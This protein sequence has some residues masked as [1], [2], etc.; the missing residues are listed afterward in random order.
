MTQSFASCSHC[1]YFLKFTSIERE[2]MAPRLRSCGFKGNYIGGCTYRNGGFA[3]AGERHSFLVRRYL[4]KPVI[5]CGYYESGF[6]VE[7]TGTTCPKCL[8]GLIVI[9]RLLRQDRNATILI[10]CSLYPACDFSTPDLTLGTK[11]PNCGS[12]LVLSAG[13]Q[14]VC[15]CPK[16]KRGIPI[17]LTVR[18]WP[19]LIISE[20]R[21]LHG[22][23]VEECDLCTQSLKERLSLIDL[24]LPLLKRYWMDIITSG[25]L[26]SLKDFPDPEM[27][28]DGAES[29][30]D[31]EN[32]L[33]SEE[34]PEDFETQEGDITYD[35][36]DNEVAW[37]QT[38]QDG[39]GNDLLSGW[40][41]GNT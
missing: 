25:N 41:Y 33:L 7:S 27:P 3:Y 10:G 31:R 18:S 6:F 21:C 29:G 38:F 36:L 2:D 4:E 39:I 22:L 20:A 1:K 30:E 12:Y 24:E 5:N 8:Q 14:L 19:N 26:A 35:D 40:F 9:T 28:I 23:K 34:L 16:C 13:D 37:I 11:C 17:P 15:G 32:P